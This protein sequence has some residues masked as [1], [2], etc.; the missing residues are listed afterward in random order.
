MKQ[1]FF[2]NKPSSTPTIYAYEMPDDS[3]KKGLLK[4]GFTNRTA[5]I[6]V[7]EQIGP[8]HSKYNIVLE[9]SAVRNDGSTFHD[10]GTVHP[11]LIKKG[12]KNPEGEWFQ[13]TEP[14]LRAALLE[15]KS[16]IQSEMIRSM[17]FTMRPEQAEAVHKTHA[18]FTSFTQE[19]HDKIPHF[20]W[21]AKMRF[22][23]TFA[24]YQLAKKNGL[25]KNTCIDI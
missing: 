6:R 13:I 7:K 8:T 1:D 3:S 23:K 11:Y 10:K 16:G 12:Y 9:E 2:P 17:N 19:H 21:N 25:D 15:I 14:E 18:Y 4:V 24:S 5:K 20:L 22:G